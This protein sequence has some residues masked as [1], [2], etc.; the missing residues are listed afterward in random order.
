MKILEIKQRHEF[1]R[2]VIIKKTPKPL[3]SDQMQDFNNQNFSK[4]DTSSDQFN[5]LLSEYLEYVNFRESPATW[6]YD[7]IN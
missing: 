7:Y 5:K 1:D 2:K 3:K 6:F 4:Y